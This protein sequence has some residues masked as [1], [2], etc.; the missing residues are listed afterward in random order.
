ME[1]NGMSIHFVVEAYHALAMLVSGRP[2][3]KIFTARGGTIFLPARSFQGDDDGLFP[4]VASLAGRKNCVVINGGDGSAH[5]PTKPPA[6]P[7]K[8]VYIGKLLESNVPADNIWTTKPATNAWLEA[9]AFVEFLVGETGSMGAKVPPVIVVAQSH[10]LLRMFLH[11]FQA[12]KEHNFF[13]PLYTACPTED[14]GWFDQVQANQGHETPR[15]LNIGAELERV[16][17]YQR[18]GGIN[19]R[20]S[21]ASFEKLFDHIRRRDALW[22]S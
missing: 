5:D 3:Q 2:N 6:W 17:K 14:I 13:F 11:L 19:G 9:Q 12:M 16:E 10:Q 4:L 8:D 15:V 21:C 20:P 22:L 18:G 7:G 1:Q